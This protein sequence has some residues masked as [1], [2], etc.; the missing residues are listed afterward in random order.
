LSTFIFGLPHKKNGRG[1]GN[2]LKADSPLAE[3]EE[4]KEEGD[5]VNLF[6]SFALVWLFDS[7][8]QLKL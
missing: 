5:D 4:V 7:F 2:F 6:N 1:E 8:F 3:W